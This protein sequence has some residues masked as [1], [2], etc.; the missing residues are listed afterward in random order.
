M[1]ILRQIVSE[2]Y[3]M[4]AGDAVMTIFTVAIVSVAAALHYLTATPAILIGL[5]LVAGCLALLIG[6]VVAYANNARRARR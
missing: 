5:G 6:R 2:I 4:F 1:T 3:S